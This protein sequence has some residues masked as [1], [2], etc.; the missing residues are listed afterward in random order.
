MLPPGRQLIPDKMT[1][2][3]NGLIS[4][5]VTSGVM[6]LFVI[7]GR[8]INLREMFVAASPALYKSLTAGFDRGCRYFADAGGRCSDRCCMAGALIDL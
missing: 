6:A 5:L 7:I 1:Q 2:F 3:I 8:T 4:G